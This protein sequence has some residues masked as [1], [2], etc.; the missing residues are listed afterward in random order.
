[1]V[2]LLADFVVRFNNAAKTHVEYFYVPHS[3]VNL[4][5]LELLFTYRCIGAFSIDIHPVNR[6][7]RLKVTPIFITNQPLIRK[8]ELVSKPGLRVY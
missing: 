4:Q 2:N 8:I 3:A 7:L 5:I 1:M 6:Q